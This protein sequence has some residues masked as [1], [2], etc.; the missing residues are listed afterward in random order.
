MS[1]IN[2]PDPRRGKYL[3]LPEAAEVLNP[4]GTRR[5]ASYMTL[6]RRY[7]EGRLETFKVEGRRCCYVEDL[8]ELFSNEAEFDRLMAAAITAA[9]LRPSLSDRQRATLA[10]VVDQAV[11]NLSRLL[12]T[13]EVA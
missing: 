10:P 8:D 6:R 1:T 12:G 5:Y 11:E 3:P 2:H 13:E 9:K 7:K 4:D